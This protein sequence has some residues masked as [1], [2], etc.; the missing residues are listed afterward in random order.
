MDLNDLWFFLEVFEIQ[1]N[2]WGNFNMLVF[3]FY[4]SFVLVSMY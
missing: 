3:C 2:R 4:C 1:I